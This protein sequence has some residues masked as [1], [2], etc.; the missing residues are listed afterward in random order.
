M[1]Y[2][3]LTVAGS[4]PSGGAG[5]QAD[6]NTFSRLGV[7][8]MSVIVALT[9][10][11]TTGVSRVMEV[12]SDFVASQWDAVMSDIPANA[13]KTGMLGN[14][15][16]I[17]VTTDMIDRYG[18]KN[19]VV[20]PVMKSTSGAKLLATE[21]IETLKKKLISRALLATPN[22]DEAGI[23]TGIDVRSQDDMEEAAKRIRDMG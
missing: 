1:I 13:V 10:Q 11:N 8:G 23:L 18:V 3:A 15:S 6:L 21:A 14:A 17:E 16:N 4:D 2:T 19:V 7:Y 22:A 20:D 12:P 5:I 9:A